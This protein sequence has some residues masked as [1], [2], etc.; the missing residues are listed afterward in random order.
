MLMFTHTW[1]LREFIGASHISRNDHDIFAYNVS[2]DLLP[3]H[4]S[5]TPG[6]THSIPRLSKL[7]QKYNR[8]AFVQFHL[9]VD[10]MA[11]HGKII[12]EAITE[13]NPNAN[14]YAYI[15][16]KPLIQPI[17]DFYRE[18][19]SEISFSET[20]YLSHMIIEMC[21]DLALYKK[22][23]DLAALFSGAL[24]YTVENKLS[25]FV[26]TLSWI[27]E[28]EEEITT[29]AT[30][31]AVAVYQRS[32][33][34][35]LMSL[36]GRISLFIDNYCYGSDDGKTR[37]GIRNLFNQGMDLVVDYEDFLDTTLT[38]INNSEFRYLL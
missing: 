21:F 23:T 10:D 29:D 36:E 15:K 19:G 8:A 12:R 3:V 13:F 20:A 17:T 30:K 24:T 7:P 1:I 34:D 33:I 31:R 27:F 16:G 26:K 14:G 37:N 22:E 32:K 28:I 11:H 6:L 9:L 18:I 25:E 2:P 35:S 5:I 38:A 4:E